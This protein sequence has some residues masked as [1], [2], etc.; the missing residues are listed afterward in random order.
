M[1]ILIK[2][3]LHPEDNAMVQAL[4]SRSP[5]SVEQHLK[6]VE[7]L[8][9]GNF[10]D[11]FYIGY[12]HDS[13]GDCGSTTIFIE[14]VSMLAAKAIQDHPLYSG[15]EAST[16]YMDFSNITYETPQHPEEG[17]V[18]QQEWLKFY[19]TN[20]SALMEHF[21]KQY[22]I[23]ESEDPAK[24]ERA[25]KARTFDVLRGFLPA[26]A[27][28]NLSWHTNLRQARDKLRWLIYHPDPSICH[29]ARV[30]AE[31]LANKY[32]HSGFD[33]LMS[34]DD[35]VYR[36]ATMRAYAL[37]SDA[38]RMSPVLTAGRPE[39]SWSQFAWVHDKKMQ[40]LLK[41]RPPRA[42]LPPAL[43][44]YGVISSHFLLDYGSFRD[45]QRHRNGFVRMP[46]LTAWH[47]FH[48]WYLE[49]MPW[50]MSHAAARL[51]EQ[52]LERIGS[53]YLSAE[54]RQHYLAMG[55]RVACSVT[56]NLPAFVYR[57]EL[58]TAQTVHPTL[59]AVTQKEAAIF[60]EMMGN[61]VP[62]HVDMSPDAW[63]TRRGAQTILER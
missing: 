59:R 37:S 25:L 5:K 8:G 16:R 27:H 58:R 6:K 1:K 4:Y 29:L 55:F 28:T 42:P 57:L 2:D 48:P 40:A 60:E 24:Y 15:Q 47:G 12:G 50:E 51:I 31:N 20:F 33:K 30:L 26:G 63:S 38:R 53:L 49:Q 46:L 32:P 62:I 9:S 22:P 10:M 36:S 18:I 11:D 3:D 45:L 21:R 44:E 34:G 35:A 43:A 39:I 52:Q 61:V 56:Q 13:I 23:A 54:E 17:A 7:K 14:G 41:A 19:N